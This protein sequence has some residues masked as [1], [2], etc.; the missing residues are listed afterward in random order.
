[1][2][3]GKATQDGKIRLYLLGELADEEA[4]RVDERLM[5]D[6]EFFREV[7][8]VEGEL[9]DEYARGALTTRERERFETHFL[10]AAERRE[11]AGF[12]DALRS[13]VAAHAP[14]PRPT[15]FAARLGAL[16]RP[17]RP[18]RPAALALTAAALALCL[19][20]LWVVARRPSAQR[21]TPVETARHD[22]PAA[23][24]RHGVARP[25][26]GEQSVTES[27]R[28]P[29]DWRGVPGVSPTPSRPA[30][31][32]A[33][34]A[35]TPRT[36]VLTLT[37]GLTR[38][39]GEFKRVTLPAGE[40]ATIRLRLK[41]AEDLYDSYRAELLAADGTPV[42]P[43]RPFGARRARSAG[44]V[45]VDIPAG[46]L[47]RGGDYQVRLSGLGAGGAVEGAGRYFF[48]TAKN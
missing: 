5:S 46:L 9:A 22:T 45:V 18:R 27:P 32:P 39:N 28:P 42:G 1:L 30:G 43:G 6:D 20:G 38:A 21:H 40:R 23:G 2:H 34:P 48:R 35:Q 41:L 44:E 25:S 4:R 12:A 19:V 3:E 7:L 10:V 37:P 17:L 13:H 24:D 26:G 14:P 36:V 33:R 11:E 29:E 16:L 47:R 8:D 15:A 31:E